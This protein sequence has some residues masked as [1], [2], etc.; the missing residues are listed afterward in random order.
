MFSNTADVD[1]GQSNRR[2]RT[3]FT[4]EQLAAFE[5]TFTQISKTPSHEEIERLVS[6]TGINRIK[7][8]VWF[9]NRRAKERRE[10]GQDGGSK[11]STTSD[12]ELETE[13]ERQ[14][15]IYDETSEEDSEI[16]DTRN[17]QSKTTIDF[18]LIKPPRPVAVDL[19]GLYHS[20]NENTSSFVPPI[21]TMTSCL[22]EKPKKR[23][24]ISE[25]AITDETPVMATHVSSINVLNSIKKDID[26]ADRD[27]ESGADGIEDF[28][29]QSKKAKTE[30]DKLD[31][32]A[33]TTR[34]NAGPECRM[35]GE[36]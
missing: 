36:T 9:Q 27:S 11:E 31:T 10:K 4:D 6:E 5:R 25:T 14:L 33:V 17:H 29:F 20:E 24:L 28:R 32:Y 13:D 8:K 1:P 22:N 21:Q 12:S 34:G 16:E 23:S 30:E 19:S 26:I 35:F 2:K 7:I 3:Q 18:K 15:S